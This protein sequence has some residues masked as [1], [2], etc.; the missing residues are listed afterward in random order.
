MNNV[1]IGCEASLR[2]GEHFH[3][4]LWIHFSGATA[5]LGPI[6]RLMR[7]I[8]RTHLDTHARTRTRTHTR[9]HTRTRTHTHTHT[10]AHTH[11]HARTHAHAH[12]RART[13]THTHARAVGLYWT[14]DKPVAGTATYTT[15]NKHM[16]IHAFSGIRRCERSNQEP[17][18]LCLRPRGHWVNRSLNFVG[19]ELNN[20]CN[21]LN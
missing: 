16:N 14:C 4:V 18:D 10:R 8:D 6:Q 5:K 17:A 11:A 3:H 12:T 19:K 9:A 13:H 2:A 21:T 15:L 1:F 20:R 7:F